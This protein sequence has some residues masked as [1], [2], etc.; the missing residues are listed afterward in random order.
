MGS[1]PSPAPEAGG[2]GVSARATRGGA[3]SGT[4]ETPRR[5]RRRKGGRAPPGGLHLPLPTIPGA[6]R[7]I[8]GRSARAGCTALGGTWGPRPQW[9]ER[10][11]AE[12]GAHDEHPLG[13]PPAQAGTARGSPGRAYL[14]CRRT[15]PRPAGWRPR[16][17]WRRGSRVLVGGDGRA[18]SA[19]GTDGCGARPLAP[20]S[21]RL[22]RWAPGLCS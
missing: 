2:R 15:C 18:R 11:G 20:R 3:G 12:T 9:V 16:R 19:G 17:P 13:T 6:S 1:E 10:G 5:A 4:G 14:G 8:P 22:M 21:W 7:S